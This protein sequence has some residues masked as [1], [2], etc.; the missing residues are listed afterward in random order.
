M[1]QTRRFKIGRLVRDKIPER[2]QSLGAKDKNHCLNPN[3]YTSQL[4]LKLLEEAK[5]V[6]ESQT[7]EELQEEIADVL[8]VL[9]SLAK[10]QGIQFEDIEKKRI[11]KREDRGGFDKGIFIE[12]IEIETEDESHPLL[13]YCFKH[14]EKYPE[15]L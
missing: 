5:E 6:V 4:K 2:M 12:Y 1:L 9:H 15:I 3:E 10:N 14:P 7:R 13:Q 11:E 8:E